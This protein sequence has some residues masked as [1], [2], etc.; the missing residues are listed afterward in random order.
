MKNHVVQKKK[1]QRRK[2]AAIHEE[3]RGMTERDKSFFEIHVFVVRAT[4][5]SGC[6]FYFVLYIF[7]ELCLV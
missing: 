6:T 2:S 4:S 7:C 5:R 1:N 3:P